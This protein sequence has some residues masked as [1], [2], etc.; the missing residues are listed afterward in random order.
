MF[1]IQIN[2]ICVIYFCNYRFKITLPNL[3][4]QF[5]AAK[6]LRNW[7]MCLASILVLVFHWTYRVSTPLHRKLLI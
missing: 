1:V 6:N 5:S 4:L 7:I 2:K 3:C